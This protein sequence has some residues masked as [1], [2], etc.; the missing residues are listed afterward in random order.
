MITTLTGDGSDSELSV[1]EEEDDDYEEEMVV[2][3]RRSSS[4][5]ALKP[6]NRLG[7]REK[8]SKF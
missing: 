2:Q 6:V 3:P 1:S 7:A 8:R 4:G 5:R